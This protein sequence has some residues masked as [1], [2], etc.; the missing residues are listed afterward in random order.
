MIPASTWTVPAAS[1]ATSTKQRI[2]ECKRTCSSCSSCFS[3]STCS[4]C[5]W[6]QL[7]LQ[8]LVPPAARLLLCCSCDCWCCL[9]LLV[10]GCWLLAAGCCLAALAAAVCPGQGVV[11]PWHSGVP[12]RCASLDFTGRPWLGSS[13]DVQLALVQALRRQFASK[14]SGG[15]EKPSVQGSEKNPLPDRWVEEPSWRSGK[16]LVQC[17]KNTPGKGGGHPLL[18]HPWVCEGL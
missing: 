8:L 11:Y 3:C 18:G 10:A 6:Q 4:C 1:T 12:R 2:C 13:L 14:P 17:Q 5:S 15:T 16:F 9:L 7:L